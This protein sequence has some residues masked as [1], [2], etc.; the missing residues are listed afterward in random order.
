MADADAPMTQCST[1]VHVANCR[2]VRMDVE[3]RIPLQKIVEQYTQPDG[4]KMLVATEANRMAAADT[5][6]KQEVGMHFQVIAHSSNYSPAC[7]A[8]ADQLVP[9]RDPRDSDS[10]RPLCICPCGPP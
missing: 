2:C 7:A 1:T 4:E 8:M 3:Q 5:M 6:I 9:A 10:V